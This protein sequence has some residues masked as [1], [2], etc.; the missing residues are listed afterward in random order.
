MAEIVIEDPDVDVDLLAE[1]E[2]LFRTIFDRSDE[3]IIIVEP[4]VDGRIIQVNQ[5]AADLHGY[6]TE[7]MQKLR[8]SDLHL[9]DYQEDAQKGVEL[10]LQG[11]WIESVHSHRRKDG[12]VFPVRNRAG[13]SYYMGRRICISF[14]TD[15]SEESKAVEELAKCELTL[16]SQL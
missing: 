9:P 4:D 12:T 14:V 8:A 7:E 13:I 15:I 3:G 6:T 2:Q 1:Y 5:A 16:S 10:M 11:D